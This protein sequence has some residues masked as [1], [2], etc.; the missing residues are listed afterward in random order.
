MTKNRLPLIRL[1]AVN[2]FLDELRR[3]GIDAAALLRERELPSEIPA[4][5]EIFVP[6]PTVYSLVEESAELAD[7]PYLGFR[8]GCQLTVHNWE[9]IA[10]AFAKADS[11]GSLFAHFVVGATEHTSASNFYLRTESNRSTFGFLRSSLPPKKTTQN[12]AFYLGFISM[13]LTHAMGDRCDFSRVL[14]TVAEPAAIPSSERQL[15]VVAGDYSG[16]HVTLPTDWL[17]EPLQRI[18]ANSVVGTA[19]DGPPESVVDS[20]RIALTP[21][22]AEPQLTVQQAATICGIDRRRLSTTL[23]TNGTSIAKLIA[24]L[25]RDRASLE[26]KTTNHKVRDIALSVG[27]TDPAIFSRAFKNWTGLSPK[28][29]RTSNTP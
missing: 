1:S 27:F 25:R 7:D 5:A 10:G 16:M 29:Y 9:P 3:R 19:A 24:E 14:F 23:K 8:I 13:L 2:P 18:T 28:K 6:A 15:R 11:V 26:L 17:F 12:D 20:V 21:H 22:I 4:S